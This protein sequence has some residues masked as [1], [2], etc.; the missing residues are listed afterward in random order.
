MFN[1]S[2]IEEKVLKFWQQDKTFQKTLDKESPHGDYVFYDGPPFATGAPHYGHLVANL[3][4]DIIPR[5]W[6]MKGYHVDR[7]WG[8]DCHG[9]PIENIVEKELNLDS[10][11]D[12]EDLGIDKFNTTCRSK[13]LTY[14]DDWRQTIDR[15]GRWVDMDDDYKTMDL[16][17]MESIWWV[18]K[19][20]WD[21]GLIYEGHKSMHICPRCETTLSQSEV[22]QGYQDVKDL[23]VIAKFEL[24]DQPKTFILAWTTTPWTLPGNVALAVGED[25]GYL[26]VKI[27]D[28]IYILA[29]ATSEDILADKKY[30]VI[31]ELKGKDL[32]G[33]KYQPLF[34]YYNNDKTENI[35]NGFKVYHADFVTIED[36]TGVVHIAPAFGED[37]ME[38]GKKYNL[39]FI[40]HVGMN[41]RFK[42]EVVD[43]KGLEV[44]PKQDTQQTDV[45]IIKYL[46]SHDLLF[47]KQKYEHSYPHCWRCDTPLLNYSTSSWFVNVLKIKEEA[48]NL[49]EKI[50]WTPVH[51][52]QGRFGK[53]L[54]GARD[55]SISRQRFWG[56]AM[57]I[58]VCDKCGTQKVIGSKD[59]LRQN[60]NQPITKLI[61]VRHGESEKNVNGIYS[62]AVDKHPLTQQGEIQAEDYKKFLADE[63]IDIIYSSEVLRARQTADII[64]KFLKKDKV[65]INSDFNE[66]H[67]GNWEE[68]KLVELLKNNKEYKTYHDFIDNFDERYLDFKSGGAES[69]N[70]VKQR[71]YNSLKKIVKNNEGKTILIVAHQSTTVAFWSVIKKFTAKQT[72]QLFKNKK[73]HLGS[74]PMEMYVSLDG[75]GD[76]Q[77]LDLHKHIVDKI[78]FKCEKCD[79]TMHRI[80]D[81]L[82]CWFESGSMPYAQLH[83]PF[84]NKEKFEDNFPAEFIGEGVDQTRAWFYYLHILATGL[85]HKP[86]FKHVIANGIVLAE[87]GKKMSKK[88]KNYPDPAIIFDKYGADPLRYYLAA[89]QVMRAEDLNF[90]EKD[91]TEQTRFFNILFNVLSFYQMFA[92]KI[93]VQTD[94]DI[95]LENILDKW[96]IARLELLKKN[97]TKKMDSYEL[98]AIREIPDFIDNLSTWYV[99]RSRD[100]FKGEDVKDKLL[101]LRTLYKV[102]L[103]LSKIMAPFM[104]FTADYLYQTLRQKKQSVHLETWPTVNA[105]LLDQRVLDYMSI[106]RK[107]V[108]L[109]LAKRAEEGIKV[110]Q[111]LGELKIKNQ[112][113]AQEYL[114]LVKDELNVK[115]IKQIKGDGDLT[116]EL[117]TEITTELKQEGLFREI[118]RA[119][120]QL[121][122]KMDLTIADKII[123]EYNTSDELLKEVFKKYNTELKRNILAEE[124][125]FIDAK[126]NETKINDIVIGIKITVK[127]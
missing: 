122:K 58:W 100:R 43:F 42:D 127:K 2:Q 15:L 74:P 118:V 21:K 39:P 31:R 105:E 66:D 75:S 65:I 77:E 36:G 76:L 29:K 13:V 60:I 117:N 96:I 103:E 54:E 52:K 61:F 86:A 50:N 44:K 47:A 20:L 3:M 9:L 23:S 28:S 111:P 85:K 53:W 67:W 79:G 22:S 95:E 38:L 69:F 4:K 18:F 107:V 108:E 98:N 101:A 80:P 40:Q 110:R 16:D 126:F 106:T 35:T 102:L 112:E 82:D 25:I 14:A 115:E 121:R 5:Y 26:Q 46:A 99:R 123:V 71:V 30:K 7:K 94:N 120:N 88:L 6:T 56:S 109:G 19:E 81:V 92:G 51:I 45:A 8:W 73:T 83:Y 62:S 70:D 55:W 97:I 91:L 41:G 48:I 113:L 57:P 116:V 114:A 125:K 90:S 72:L 1:L 33:K 49:A 34:P 17:Y 78:H 93:E 10:K 59:E 124:I 89:S 87:D 64:N 27:E 24:V 63:N 104:P 119:I 37:D 84:E 11:K 12:I 68:A 32:V